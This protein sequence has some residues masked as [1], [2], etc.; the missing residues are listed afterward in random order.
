MT[1]LFCRRVH[2]NP[3]EIPRADEDRKWDEL[4]VRAVLQGGCA[5]V[6]GMVGRLAV[7]IYSSYMRDYF[8]IPHIPIDSEQA[9]T[10]GSV[11]GG[12]LCGQIGK[13]L[14]DQILKNDPIDV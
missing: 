11:V 4:K 14:A 9:L 6:G 8:N 13:W 12:I 1:I 5:V 3:H 10:N 2:E 7:H